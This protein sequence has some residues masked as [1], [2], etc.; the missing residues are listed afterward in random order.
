M[1][2]ILFYNRN[3]L[4]GNG[5][6]TISE[7]FSV[8][9]HRGPDSTSI[10]FIDNMLF[11]HHRLA[12]I[13]AT[14][15]EQPIIRE[16]NGNDGKP[17]AYVL[18]ANGEIYNYKTFTNSANDCEAI[19]DAYLANRL[20]DLDGD[21]AFILYD[22]QNRLIITGRDPV[23]LKPLYVGFSNGV[24][25]AFG[26][27]MKVLCAIDTI[28]DV[29]EHTINTFNRFYLDQSG[30]M[31]F[32]DSCTSI[33][34]NLP[35]VQQTYEYAQQA[36]NYYLVN[37][38]RKRI[39]HTERPF[40]FLC[41]GG[42]D[43]VIVVAIAIYL[44]I[45]VHVFNLSLDSGSSFD[46]MHADMF[47]EELKKRPGVQYT[48][49]K[50]S[51]QEGLSIVDEI[52][53]NLETYDPNTIRAS[54]PMYLLA[55]FIKNNTDYK[56][57][58][59]GEGSDEIFM[60]YN[61]FGIKSPTPDQA[62]KESLRLIQGLHSFDI[63][64]AERCFSCHGLELRVPFLDRELISAAIQIPGHYRLPVGGV[65]KHLLRTAFRNLG[66]NDRLL[67]RQKERMSDGVGGSWVPAII[68]Y[69]VSQLGQD[70][71][72][73][74]TNDRMKYEK[75]FYKQVYMKYYPYDTILFREMPNWAMSEQTDEVMIEDPNAPN[76]PQPNQFQPQ[77]QPN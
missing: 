73:L 52:I 27:E 55:K 46:E 32:H 2:G 74:K 41:S 29:R 8:I 45:P 18:I 13:N 37:A 11:C 58:L 17:N 63:L 31:N 60:G 7:I 56:V 67:F 21:F 3:N 24:P 71:N 62:E 38:V 49:V 9:K 53:K 4:V 5:T 36:I 33:N 59:S 70:P 72:A 65:E 22:K 23:G 35:I 57:I 44:G 1:C 76:I 47:M 14:G 43:S 77:Q 15:G 51:I 10:N 30:I 25:V 69:A 54:V 28:N 64:R 39:I 16:Q 26:S 75:Q 6:K 66:I 68:N 12:I 48:K 20:Q 19:I 61:Y 50:F 40:A 42:I 34:Y